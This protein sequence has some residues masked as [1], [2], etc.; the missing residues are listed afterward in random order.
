MKRVAIK[1]LK[2]E[3]N[4]EGIESDEDEIE[5]VIFKKLQQKQGEDKRY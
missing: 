3:G 5:A 4:D 2:K 1:V